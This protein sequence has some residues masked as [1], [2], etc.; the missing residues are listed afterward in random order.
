MVKKS[1]TMEWWDG[2]DVLGIDGKTQVHVETLYDCLDKL[3]ELPQRDWQSPMRLPVS[4]VYK[5]KGVGDVVTGRLEQGK[6]E[7]GADV[8]FVPTHTKANPCTGQLV[9]ME[10]GSTN[11]WSVLVLGTTSV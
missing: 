3:V 5:I 9:V 7:A 10:M 2:H 4:G 1:L 6:V 8:V 11:V